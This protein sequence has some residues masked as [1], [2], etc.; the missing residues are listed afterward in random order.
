MRAIDQ[1]PSGDV[2]PLQGELGMWRLRIGEWRVRFR[3]DVARR[4]ID[5]TAVRGR[6]GAYKP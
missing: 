4:R 2:R 1:L 3:L 5:V 6:G